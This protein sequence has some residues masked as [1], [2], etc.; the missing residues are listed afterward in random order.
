MFII[1]ALFVVLA[2]GSF[3]L[4]S[5]FDRRG[6]QARVLRER[7]SAVEQASHRHPGEELALLRD[8]V[9]SSVPAL[10]EFLKRSNRVA[11]LQRFLSQANVKTRAGKFL[12]ISVCVAVLCGLLVQQVFQSAPFALL[13]ILV[14]GSLPAAFVA[15]RRQRRF[16]RFEA[17]FPEAI[18]LLARSIRAGHAF[19]TSLEVIALELSEPVAGEFRK[20]YDEQRFGLPMREALLNLAERVPIFDV[21][22]FVTAVLLQRRAAIWPRYWTSSLT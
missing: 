2:I 21:K 10:N 3:A 5:G 15:W 17:L 20:I 9:L 8:E 14:A 13:G 18:D 19:N 11:K 12:L 16:R 1:L 4:L 7:L 6:E 22:F